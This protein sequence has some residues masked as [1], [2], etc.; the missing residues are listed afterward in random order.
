MTQMKAALFYGP[1]KGLEIGYTTKPV[2][3]PNHILVKI[4]ASS[5]CHSDFTLLDNER[6]APSYPIVPG[7]E[8]ECQN[9]RRQ[10]IYYY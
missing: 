8:G 2:P 4:K 10:E 9:T 3:A 5:L 6:P 7:H 1:E